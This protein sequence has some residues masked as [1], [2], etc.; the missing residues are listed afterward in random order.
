MKD[1]FS[2][3]SKSY[4]SFRPTYPEALYDFIYGHVKNF[5]L[6]WDAGTGNGQA[7]VALA[8][9]FKRVV[10]TDISAQQLEQA[11]QI[12][13]IE[14]SVGSEQA[15]LPDQSTDLI[16]AAQAIHWFDR[17]KFFAEVRRVGKPGSVVAVWGYGLLSINPSINQHLAHFY[18]D[19][20]GPYWDPERKHID[21]RF[22]NT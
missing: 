16:T 20:I 11:E 7:A 5:D 1:L 6:V 10:A 22:R 13:N 18:K 21:D 8:A 12:S 15:D 17:R 19:I 4:A 3:N 14:Y 9:K 2:S